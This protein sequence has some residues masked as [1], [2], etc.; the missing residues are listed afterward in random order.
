MGP[1]VARSC[2][3]GA[4]DLVLGMATI[5]TAANTDGHFS[6]MKHYVLFE[7]YRNP[8]SGGSP[9]LQPRTLRLKFM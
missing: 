1:G 3:Q 4:N 7:L 5:M 8:K 6:Y 2:S 9:I